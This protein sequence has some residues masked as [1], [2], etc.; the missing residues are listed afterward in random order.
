MSGDR[1]SSSCSAVVLSQAPFLHPSGAMDPAW[2]AVILSTQSRGLRNVSINSGQQHSQ[3]RLCLRIK[4]L[5]RISAQRAFC[6]AE[7]RGALEP[8]RDGRQKPLRN[9][10]ADPD[11]VCHGEGAPCEGSDGGA[12]TAAQLHAD[13]HKGHFQ[14][15]QKGRPG[16]H[17]SPTLL[18]REEQEAETQLL[19]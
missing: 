5:P 18:C 11:T 19:A 7:E 4:Q 1:T 3:T 15:R 9:R 2:G 14:C 12:D 6:P 17:V 16:P 8:S 10:Y 13:C